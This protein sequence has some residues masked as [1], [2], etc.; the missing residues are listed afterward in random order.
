MKIASNLEY[1]NGELIRTATTSSN[2][3]KGTRAGSFNKTK[4]YR[5]VWLNGKSYY[6]HVVIWEAFN[7]P[8]PDGMEIDHI[9]RI[10]DDN[11]IE[12]LRLLPTQYNRF[13]TDAKGVSYYKDR[14]KWIA[15][16]QRDHKYIYLGTYDTEEEATSAYKRA[17][18]IH[19]KE[20]YNGGPK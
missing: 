11:R 1:S 13:N 16:I 6:E 5:S 12:N 9:N 19:H 15:R 8:V 17:K 20:I 2:A 10:K 4:G 18:Q 14:N 7:G 3:I